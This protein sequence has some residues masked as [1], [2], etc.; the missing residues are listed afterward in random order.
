MKVGGKRRLFIPYQL[1]YGEQ[2]RGSIPPK[3]ELIFDV[4]LLDVGDAP[5]LG[6]AVDVLPTFTELESKVLAL[7]KAVPE[8]K[9]S[10]RPGPRTPSFAEIFMGIP[11]GNQR[12]LHQESPPFEPTA[13]KQRVLELLSENLSAIRKTLEAARPSVFKREA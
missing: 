1:A 10:W 5:Q 13:G 6:A 2:G 7:A 12:L 3:A 9:Y 11:I 4:E 8:E